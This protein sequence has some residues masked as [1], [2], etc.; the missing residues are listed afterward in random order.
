MSWQPLQVSIVP[1]SVAVATPASEIRSQTAN[2][3]SQRNWSSKDIVKISQNRRPDPGPLFIACLN[4][5]S[6]NLDSLSTGQTDCPRFTVTR[7]QAENFNGGSEV[8]INNSR[9]TGQSFSLYGG[10]LTGTG[11]LIKSWVTGHPN[12][13]RTWVYYGESSWKEGLPLATEDC[14]TTGESGITL[15]R[16]TWK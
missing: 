5:V 1:A 16:W 3:C 12:D 9:T 14:I 2:C 6:T 4:Y 8:V 10:T 15:A 11:T 13:L 7:N